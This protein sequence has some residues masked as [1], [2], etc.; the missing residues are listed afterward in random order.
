MKR[1][2][3]ASVVE[4]TAH[5]IWELSAGCCSDF[6]DI[7]KTWRTTV[8]KDNTDRSSLKRNRVP[9]QLIYFFKVR[10]GQPPN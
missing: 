10:H 9:L 6:D 4:M 7:A 1:L 5:D 3:G 8:G 2:K